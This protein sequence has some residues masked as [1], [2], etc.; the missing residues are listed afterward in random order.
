MSSC[1]YCDFGLHEQKFRSLPVDPVCGRALKC[2]LH[3]NMM[4]IVSGTVCKCTWNLYALDY[5]IFVNTEA[6]SAYR[7][8]QHWRMS[9]MLLS[10]HLKLGMLF[11]RT[12]FVGFMCNEVYTC[13][14]IY[15]PNNIIIIRKTFSL[16][17]G[18]STFLGEFVIFISCKS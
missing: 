3:L 9:S 15:Y 17:Y 12:D 13:F 1:N 5:T 14:G 11:Q 10:C 2:S 6:L 16:L 4:N 7:N 18:F 8:C